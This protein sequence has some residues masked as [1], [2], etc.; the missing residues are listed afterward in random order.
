MNLQERRAQVR[1]L[2]AIG[3]SDNEIARRLGRDPSSTTKMRRTMGLPAHFGVG[4]V[5]RTSG[6]VRHRRPDESALSEAVR[7]LEQGGLLT[8]D[9]AEAAGVHVVTA[10]RILNDLVELGVV[11]RRPYRARQSIYEL[12]A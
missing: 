7:L 8:T 1:E 4:G 12:A 2:H 3:L 9:L 11:R 6:Q 5:H 10:R